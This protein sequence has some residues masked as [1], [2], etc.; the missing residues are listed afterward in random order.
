MHPV[1]RLILDVVGTIA[2]ALLLLGGWFSILGGG[3][4]EGVRVLLNFMDIGLGVWV[5]L[6]V[7]FSVRGSRQA[8]PPV[9]R[10]LLAGAVVNL[11][12]VTT[13]GFMQT[14]GWTGCYGS[15]SRPDRI[16]DR[17]GHRGAAGP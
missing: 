8:R 13:V 1:V 7:V 11:L 2:L 10:L 6:L 12:V 16:P 4:P 9:F 14:G 5:V 3:F 15:P 17:G